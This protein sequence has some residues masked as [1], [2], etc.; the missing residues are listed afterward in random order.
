M[1]SNS[2]LHKTLVS[3]ELLRILYD[4]NIRRIIQGGAVFDI[5]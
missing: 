2:T 5:V 1:K 3:F 4:N